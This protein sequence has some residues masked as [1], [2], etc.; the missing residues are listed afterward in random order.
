MAGGSDMAC[1]AMEY[2]SLTFIAYPSRTVILLTCSIVCHLRV[3]QRKRRSKVCTICRPCRVN[4]RLPS[5]HTLPRMS[6]K[7]DYREITCESGYES[8]IKIEVCICS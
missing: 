6:S 7:V 1:R 4:H 3:R 2:Q 5:R 8:T